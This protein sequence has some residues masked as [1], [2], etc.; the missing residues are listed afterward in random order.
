VRRHGLPRYALVI[1]CV[2]FLE[3]TLPAAEIHVSPSGRDDSGGSAVAPL[4]TVS[5]AQQAA[6]KLAGRE[7]ISVVLHGGV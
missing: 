2:F 3:S 1:A 5:A 4:R 6:R 7:P